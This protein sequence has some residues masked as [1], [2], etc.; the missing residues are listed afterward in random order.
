[1]RSKRTRRNSNPSP[2]KIMQN[3][4]M[5]KTTSIPPQVRP[6]PT[7]ETD[8]QKSPWTTWPLDRFEMA[9]LGNAL[10]LNPQ[11]VLE[12]HKTGELAPSLARLGALARQ[13]YA[14]IEV[15]LPEEKLS[16]AVNMNPLLAG[17][18]D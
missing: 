1:M 16:Y 11:A 7:P 15:T 13:T 8:L 17:F 14:L 9:I 3:L 5:P 18:K 6:L 4:K 10:A 12:M 2:L